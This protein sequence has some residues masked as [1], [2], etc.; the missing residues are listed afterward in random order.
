L[1][2]QRY[3]FYLNYQ[4][5][6]SIFLYFLHFGKFRLYKKEK[7]HPKTNQILFSFSTRYIY[8][9]KVNKRKIQIYFL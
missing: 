9:Q 8:P 5:F 7:S 4:N 1:R 6:S 3:G 2:V